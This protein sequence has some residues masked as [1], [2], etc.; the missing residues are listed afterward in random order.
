M[1]SVIENMTNAEYHA[2]PAISKSGLDLIDKSPAHY[3]YR[4]H[5]TTP[6]MIIGSAFHDLVLLP[7]SFNSMYS[8]LPE[9]VNMRTKEGKALHEKI[10]S[11]GLTPIS[12]DDFNIISAMKE[13]VF[14]HFSASKLLENGQAETSIF[15]TDETDVECRCRPDFITHNGI[16]VDLKST[17][18]ASPQGFAKSVANYR[19]HVQDA[20]Y[21]HGYRH[22]FGTLPQG[23]VF[24]A[25]EKVPPYAVAVYTLDD[26]A[27][28]EGE[29]RF[30]ENLETYKQALDTNVWT[31]FSSKIETL[32][33]PRWAF[34]E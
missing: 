4:E 10:E 29:F 27:K 1:V 30:K 19:Y 31:A 11:E 22:A 32:S 26:I 33:L 28:L 17:T 24:I 13:S 21:S 7:G 8:V 16:I 25:V 6:A 23:F 5:K 15:W 14:A 12:H 9:G 34:K 3:F 20:Y 2:H 18:D